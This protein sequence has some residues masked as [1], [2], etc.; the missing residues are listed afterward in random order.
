MF[1][2]PFSARAC[3]EP[4]EALRHARTADLIVIDLSHARFDGLRLAARIR[5]DAE[6]RQTP[7][8]GIV[9]SDDRAAMVRALDLGVTDVILRPVDPG[10]LRSARPHPGAPQ[11]LCRRLARPV[12]RKS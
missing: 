2:T 6:T 5:S 3:S 9:E 1:Q 8:L 12:G 10:E 4:L 7:I 11:S